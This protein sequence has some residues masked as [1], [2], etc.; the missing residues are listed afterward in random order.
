MST[1]PSTS[2]WSSCPA[3][4]PPSS[5][6]VAPSCLTIPSRSR[7]STS[8]RSPPR[9]ST[10]PRTIAAASCGSGYSTLQA[11]I[12]TKLS[13]LAGDI[14]LARTGFSG[15]QMTD[16]PVP[17]DRPDNLFEPLPD[18]AATHG[19]FDDQ[20][21]SRSPQLWLSIHR[22]AVGG[23]ARGRGRRHRRRGGCRTAMS[24]VDAPVAD[25]RAAA[26]RVPTE[27]PESDGTLEWDAVTVVV[28]EVDAGGH[29][30]LGY[31]YTDAAAVGLIAGTL[32]RRRPRPRR[33][34]HRRRVVGDGPR[35]PQPRVARAQRH[36]DL[37]GRRCPVGPQG[38][39]A[40]GVLWPISS[41]APGTPYPSTGPAD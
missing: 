4:T 3:S 2:P 10:G 32:G 36:R 19:I 6:G 22:R 34:G 29:T 37:R 38:Q 33:H 15:Q 40:G 16:R 31:T 35:H 28:A 24:A 23:A 30:G 1:A 21:K 11:I 14:Y 7:P 25:V 39:A 41:A 8:P 18:K 20:A 17:P 12:G 9:R 5:T 26:Y 27:Q 13:A